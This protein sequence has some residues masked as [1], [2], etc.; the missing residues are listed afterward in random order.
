MKYLIK[1]KKKSTLAKSFNELPIK[2]QQQVNKIDHSHKELDNMNKIDFDELWEQQKPVR[3]HSERL[4]KERIIEAE[5]PEKQEPKKTESDKQGIKE[6]LALP[7]KIFS[8][9]FAKAKGKRISTCKKINCF[10]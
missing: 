1:P 10:F 9:N 6:Y 2:Q 7:L 3:T 8:N 4:G 5:K